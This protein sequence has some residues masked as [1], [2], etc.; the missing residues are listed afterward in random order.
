MA[1]PFLNN[2]NLDDNQLLNAKL[3]VT[4]TVPA[5][6]Q[7]QIYFNSATGFL[8][9]RVHDGADW[10]NLL[11]TTSILNGTYITSTVTNN[12]DLTL[13]LSA[14]NGTAVAATRFLSKDNT[15]DVPAF[16]TP[17][18][19]NNGTLTMTTSTGLDGGTQTF[20]ANQAGNTTFAV[21]LNLNEL[22]AGGTLIA[23]DSIIALNGT[24]G[25][26]QLISAIPLSIFNNDLP[27][28]SDATITLAAGDILDG[29]GAFTLNQAAN[30]TI[31]FDLATGGAG[32]GSYGSANDS[33]KLDTITLDAYGRVTAVAT[34]ATGQV[35][36]VVSGNT[37]T[38]S[39]SGT[40]NKT[41]TP[42]TAAVANGGAALATGDQIYDFVTGQIANIPSGLSFEGNWNANTDTPDLSGASPD[43]GQFWI[44]SVAGNTD[45]DGI[46]DWK[47]GDWA[48]YVST[49]AGT[50]GWQKVDNTSTLSGSGVANQLTYWTGT[51]NVAGDAGLTYDATGNNL[52]VGGTITSS[53]GNSG[54]WNTGYDNMITN[55]SDSGSGI[56]TLTLTQQDGGTL[57]TSF[58]NPQGTMSSWTIKEGNG[59]ES[60]EVSNGETLTIGQ[61]PGISSEMTST[62][63]GGTIT[64]TN[65][66]KGSSQNI[67]K[68]VASS[69]G[70]AVADNNNDTLTIVGA[71]GISTAVTGDTLTITSSNGNSSHTYAE[72]IT[73][74]DLTID[75]NFDTRDI[76]VQLFDTVTFET[77]Y[78]DVDR[79]TVDRLGVTFSVTPTNSVRVLIQKI[80]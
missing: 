57:A 61:G 28:A 66:D 69:S 40:V 54:E 51:A 71:G 27:T 26:K 67:F 52:T 22:P 65:T 39:H 64:I 73:D 48:I 59:A 47:V 29:G 53:G 45:L 15:W 60:T 7:G 30:E 58:V 68:N 4:G 35:N 44:V 1:I 72:T 78:A 75:H 8:K 21:S 14:V 55:F 32:A 33:I 20:S 31:T 36:T 10:L 16:P 50:D 25:S 23:T 56:I 19:V 34:G 5:A 2:I 42:V 77:V 11:D 38:L 46:T 70:T 18:T 41:L 3:Q 37:S 9:P 62:T 49:G 17:P 12:V 6:E 24:V 76:I 63:S 43:N 13:D 79:I 80:G 74:T